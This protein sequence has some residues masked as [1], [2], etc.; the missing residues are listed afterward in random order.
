MDVEFE[1]R[2]EG[3]DAARRINELAPNCQVVY[4]TDYIQYSVDVYQTDHVWFIV[5]S[6]FERRL[7]ELFEK[8]AR[9]EDAKRSSIVLTLKDRSVLNVSCQDVICFERNKR[10]TYITTTDAVYETPEK[11]SEI[12][13]KLPEASFAY[14]HN[15]YVVNLSHIARIYASELVFDNGQVAPISRRYGKHFRNRYFDWAEQWTV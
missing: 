2:P 11:L 6:Q 1:G 15:S 5:K 14:S 4:L 7:P 10:V 3:I 8:L 9:I 13:K 12:I